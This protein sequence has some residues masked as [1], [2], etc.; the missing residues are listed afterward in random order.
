MAVRRFC[1]RVK[2]HSA[3][4]Y[5]ELRKFFDNRLPAIR[6]MQKWLQCIDASPGITKPALDV[7]KEKVT[8]YQSQGKELTI[9]ISSDEASIRKHSRWND[10]TV[11]FEG[12]SETST[13]QSKKKNGKQNDKSKVP[14]VKDALVFMAVGDD[15][16]ITVGYQLLCGMNAVD[17]AAFTLE[18]IESVEKTGAKVISL[19]SDGLAANLAVAKLLGADFKQHKTYFPSPCRL[20][21]KIYVI[22][23]PCHM[24]KLLRKYLSDQNLWHGEDELKWEYLKILAERQD[25]ENYSLSK[26]LTGNHINWHDHKMN[27]KKAVQIFSN[28][29]ADVLEQLRLDGYDQFVGSEKLVEFLRLG[30]NI[31]DVMNHGEGKKSDE[32][33]KQ[34]LSSS[35]YEKF[36]DLFKL[37]KQF[38][39]ELTMEV[40]RKKTIK[41]VRASTQM[42]F[43]GL[44][45]NIESTIGIYEDYVKNC[46][47]GVF[48]T[49]KYSQ[50]HLETW[51]SLMRSGLGCNSNPTPEQCRYTYRS[52]L[53][54][55]P[56]ICK[57]VQT[58]CNVD[59]PHQ[60]LT[61]SSASVQGPKNID[62]IKTILFSKAI[63]IDLDYDECINIELEPYDQHVY[64]LVASTVESSIFQSI[65]SQNLSACQ[66]CLYVFNENSK[67]EDSLIASRITKGHLSQQP[68]ISTIDIILASEAVNTALQSHNE[69]DFAS[70]VKTIF[71][72]VLDIDSLYEL[73]NFEL[74]CGSKVDK[75]Y[76][77]T[78]K[79][80]FI[81]KIV[82]SFLNTKA[83]YICKKITLEE[84]R[85]ERERRK[86]RRNKIVAGR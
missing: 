25:N 83:R 46:P 51:F 42:G 55:S 48:Y 61:V 29:N 30:N 58:N 82:L 9:C 28:E 75:G 45:I 4:A 50:D 60:L 3:A 24:M 7:I 39:S 8:L 71:A 49:F 79:E 22:F 68:C 16:R 26:K 54:C 80:E 11:S 65:H 62:T 43:A 15:F 32:N 12:F 84:Q 13:D 86:I 38:V 44:L 27:V 57:T 36:L 21:G 52:L 37:F 81:L 53:Y 59:F 70:V 5:R 40:K 41:R 85:E 76:S 20:N 63:E 2:F 78:H 69:L 31:F 10:K 1:L 35:T 34:P 67:I 6:T 77:I 66:D 23:D 72:N 33:F 17:R 73:S 47:P 18:V 56:H 14:L 74:H 64:A 19:T